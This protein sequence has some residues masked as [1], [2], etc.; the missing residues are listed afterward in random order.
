MYFYGRCEI[1][2]D[3]VWAFNNQGTGFVLT[4]DQELT[5]CKAQ[6]SGLGGFRFIDVDTNASDLHSYNNGV[7]PQFTNGQNWSAGS[8]C[9]YEGAVYIAA[10]S[11]T[12]Y[13]GNPLTDTTDWLAPQRPVNQSSTRGQCNACPEWGVAYWFDSGGCT[14]SSCQVSQTAADAF[15]FNNAGYCTVS[16]TVEGFNYNPDGI[17]KSTNPNYYS[18]VT[19]NNSSNNVI[20]ISVTGAGPRVI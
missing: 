3:D 11:L 19:L 12:S 6:L 10:S 9:I 13:S 1:V 7:T 16:G 20:N 8:H 14:L 2:L 15:Y 4:F 18:A 5:A 17:A